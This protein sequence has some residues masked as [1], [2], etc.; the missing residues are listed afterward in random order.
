[1][2]VRGVF[3]I[4]PEYKHKQTGLNVGRKTFKKRTG[5]HKMLNTPKYVRQIAAGCTC[6]GSQGPGSGVYNTVGQTLARPAGHLASPSP[7][8]WS[9]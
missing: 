6:A 9:T 7:F 8:L 2:H 1:M 4:E 5:R 3:S